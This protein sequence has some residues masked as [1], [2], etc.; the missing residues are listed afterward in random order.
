M[1]TQGTWNLSETFVHLT[2]TVFSAALLG[3]Q[4][5]PNV[6]TLPAHGLQMI[7]SQGHI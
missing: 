5:V 4:F 1:H 6:K 3:E 7:I 2:D